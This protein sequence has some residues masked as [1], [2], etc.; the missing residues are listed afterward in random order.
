MHPTEGCALRELDERS[1]F[2]RVTHPISN[3]SSIKSSSQQHTTAITMR[4]LHDDSSSQAHPNM[5]SAAPQPRRRRRRR[6]PASMMGLFCVSMAFGAVSLPLTSGFSQSATSLES[7]TVKE[8][9]QLV[10]DNC[11]ERGVLSK[12]KRKQDLLDYLEENSAASAPVPEVNDVPIAKSTATKKPL[13]MPKASSA[14]DHAFEKVFQRY[15]PVRALT[16][17]TS[18]DND[19]DVRQ[20]YHPIIANSTS[21]MDVVF[22]G[23]AS[24]TPGVTRGV[25]CTAL[26]LNWRRRATFID[27]DTGRA[28]HASSFQ[29][30]TW[31]FD[32]G[33]CT[34][35]GPR[36]PSILSLAQVYDEIRDAGTSLRCSFVLCTVEATH[37]FN[38]HRMLDHAVIAWI[39][40]S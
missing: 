1:T 24:C 12:L 8:L 20:E 38:N 37:L 28:E 22:I 9:R 16:A 14:K 35:V 3:Q 19:V 17:S 23:T 10:K 6:S 4:S 13:Q 7:L 27:P 21:D 2:D 25:S 29:G 34:Q 18:D 30:G 11:S 26:R 36:Q 31:I 39:L 15:P 32:V 33:E 5:T 40:A